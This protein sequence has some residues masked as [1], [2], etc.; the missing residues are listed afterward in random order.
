MDRA[1]AISRLSDSGES[2]DFI[3][4]GGGAT[5]LG[6]AVDAATRGYRVALLEQG[7][8][9][10]STSSKSTK[11]VHGGVRYL[12]GGEV[13]LVRESLRERG[14]LLRNAPGLVRP[15][16]FVVPAYRLFD[17]FFYGSGLTLYDLL[18]GDLGIRS[19][20]HLSTGD[21]LDRIP[22]LRESGLRGGTLYWDAQFDDARLA[23]AMARTASE[24]GAALANHIRVESLVRGQGRI[25]GVIAVDR[26]SGEEVRLSG[27]V[28]INAT[29]VFTDSVRE[30]DEPDSGRI[31]APSQ[32][33]HLVL[34]RRFLGGEVAMML[35][36]TDDGRVL[37]AIP[38]MNRT[39]LGTTD[40]AGVDVELNP[41]PLRDEIDYLLEHA[42][43]Y[44]A[45]APTRSDIRATFAGLRPLVREGG[46][47]KGLSTSK[48]S[49]DHYLAVSESG[50]VTMAGGKWTTYRQM[51]EDAVDRAIEVGGLEGRPCRTQDLPLSGGTLSEGTLSGEN[52]P[53]GESAGPAEENLEA[54]DR[55]HPA[56]PYRWTDVE[57]AVREEMAMTVPDVLARRLRA[58]FIDSEAAR[59]VAPG[60]AARMRAWLGRDEAW[61]REQLA[62]FEDELP[63]FSAKDQSA[64]MSQSPSSDLSEG[65]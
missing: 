38:W 10:E 3:V 18:A 52:L 44:L 17:R 16:S 37:F 27:R 36:S 41:R 12:R 58:L 51:A 6:I 2:W 65:S 25:S 62:L 31:I 63:G 43:R 4:I 9:S 57:K 40:T 60:T 56:L 59:Q 45:E 11:L 50:L 24:H 34:D 61:E 30:M 15:L 49:R 54:G 42:G 48:I 47:D 29:G 32:G 22:N 21:T 1:A 28:V 20:E 33:I 26:L 64:P 19:T 35:P 53:G 55:L 13:G 7:D 23:V 39:L 5:G 8:F 14:R 46:G